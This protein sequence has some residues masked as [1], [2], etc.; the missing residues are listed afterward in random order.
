MYVLFYFSF[1]NRLERGSIFDKVII[2]K[3]VTLFCF[4]SLERGFKLLQLV[5]N[6]DVVDW[7]FIRFSLKN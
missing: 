7:N 2:Y 3:Y 6:F 4:Y 5:K 1:F